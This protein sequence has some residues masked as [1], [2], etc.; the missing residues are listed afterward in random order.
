MVRGRIRTLVLSLLAAW[1][2]PTAALAEYPDKPIRFIVP[3]APGSATDNV[4]RVFANDFDIRAL[5]QLQ[6]ES[7]A[8][9]AVI[10]G[11]EHADFLHTS[12]L[13]G[14]FASTVGSSS[15][16]GLAYEMFVKAVVPSGDT[17]NGVTCSTD[18][19]EP[20]ADG[21]G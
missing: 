3:Q 21:A 2:L 12:T 14:R 19:L 15:D 18:A 9:D 8:N 4:A 20:S 16:A 7:F 11:N 17:C 5:F 6:P 10:I 13:T 1:S